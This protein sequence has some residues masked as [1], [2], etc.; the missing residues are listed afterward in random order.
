MLTAGTATA[1]SLQAG[2]CGMLGAK[3]GGLSGSVLR[4]LQLRVS[5]VAHQMSAQDVART[6]WAF[7]TTR[8]QLGCAETPVLAQLSGTA[9]SMHIQ[10]VAD[11]L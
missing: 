6:V 9:D 7:A 4:P 2:Q 3:Q 10:H 11:V 1:G 5:C 8:E